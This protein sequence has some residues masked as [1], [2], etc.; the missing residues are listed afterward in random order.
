[1][2]IELNGQNKNSF[3]IQRRQ[4][5]SPEDTF[6]SSINVPSIQTFLSNSAEM[7]KFTLKRKQKV[8]ACK[9][10]YEW[11]K[12]YRKRN[13]IITKKIIVLIGLH[14]LMSAYDH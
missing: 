8:N 11:H 3:V 14:I 5:L 12:K 10:S 1:M 13:K 7:Y 6:G 4:E 2:R 9:V